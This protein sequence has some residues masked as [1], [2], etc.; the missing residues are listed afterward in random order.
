MDETCREILVSLR[1]YLDGECT[2]DLE[3]VVARHLVDCP[4]C[5]DRAD[6]ER[7]LQVIIRQRCRESAPPALVDRVIRRLGS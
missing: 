7:E 3:D 5:L 1:T 6:F 4:P 2:D